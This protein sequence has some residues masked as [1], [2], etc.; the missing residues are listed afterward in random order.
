MRYTAGKIHHRYEIQSHIGIH[1][2]VM[3]LGCPGGVPYTQTIV[4][5]LYLGVLNKH[6]ILASQLARPSFVQCWSREC[7]HATLHCP[8][9]MVIMNAA[10][11]CMESSVQMDDS[12]STLRS[13]ETIPPSICREKAILRRLCH[14]PASHVLPATAVHAQL[15]RCRLSSGKIREKKSG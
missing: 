3:V 15:L 7:I 10:E 2:S 8:S 6:I 12:A 11:I 4:L 13:R 5:V 14:C 9:A 1:D